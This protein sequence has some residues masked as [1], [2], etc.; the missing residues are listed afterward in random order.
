MAS[1]PI[2]S[3]AG[4]TAIYGMGTVVPRL[5]N[6]LLVPFYTYTLDKAHY[7]EVTELYAYV[8][9][10][11]ALLTY[12]METSFFR[13]SQRH[14]TRKV[15]S[16][17]Q[18][19][20]LVT[21]G[22]FLL[23]Y[24]FFYENLAQL[25]RYEGEKEY[26]LFIGLIVALDALTAIPFALLRKQNKAKR[27]ALLKIINVSVNIGLNVLF[28]LIIPEKALEISHYFFGDDSGLVV[29][30]LISNITASLLSLILLIPQ[31][32]QM[33]FK[34]DWELLKPMLRYALPILIVS[35]AGMINDV[36]DKI[37]I[38]FLV[39]DQTTA[40]EQLGVY[41]A[42]YKLAVLMTIFVQMFRYASEP[43]FF[44]HAE[45]KESPQLFAKVMNYFVLVGLLIFLGI[46]LYLDIVIHVLGKAYR[47]GAAIVPIVLLA[48]LF[49]GIF[50]NLS[51]WYKLTDKT[52]NGAVISIVGASITLFCNF[53]LIPRIGIMGAAWSHFACYFV[54]MSFS[55]LWSRKS[56]F[57]VPYNMLRIGIY[58]AIAMLIYFISQQLTELSFALR[59]TLNTLMI[60][61]FAVS[62]FCYETKQSDVKV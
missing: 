47:E 31:M 54:M 43:F 18:S 37:L 44:S 1:N 11:L 38:K 24:G 23:L 14:D 2:K 55:Y 36:I 58:F 3:L 32:R 40:M 19:S 13:F 4:Q 7:G 20:I 39:P 5:L 30:I 62:F 56:D 41:G 10:L 60:L 27:F 49:Y 35:L 8:A 48:N 15:L 21:S 61:A 34:I 57:V 33:R 22:I 28:I 59:M 53:L 25:I 17:A 6:W 45:N 9:F 16:T 12:G 42:N 46:T 26:V 52:Q 51:V 50:F 29:W